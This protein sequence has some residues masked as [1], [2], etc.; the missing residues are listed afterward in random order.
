MICPARRPPKVMP[1]SGCHR[2]PKLMPL[3]ATAQPLE[4]QVTATGMSSG[5]SLRHKNPSDDLKKV[6]HG[7]GP[8]IC[9]VVLLPSIRYRCSHLDK[10]IDASF[11]HR[12]EGFPAL[13]HQIIMAHEAVNQGPG[14]SLSQVRPETLRLASRET[15]PAPSFCTINARTLASSVILFASS[16]LQCPANASL[17]P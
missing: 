16:T 9:K 14:L 5:V 6:G 17:R 7:T 12:L 3:G 8:P 10:L 1:H 15:Q 4:C 2:P 13:R 11:H